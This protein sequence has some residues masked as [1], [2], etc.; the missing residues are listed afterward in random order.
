[1]QNEGKIRTMLES[2]RE[3]QEHDLL[4]QLEQDRSKEKSEWVRG[5]ESFPSGNSHLFCWRLSHFCSPLSL[6]PC[7]II[8]IFQMQGIIDDELSKPL[9][10][11]EDYMQTFEA[12]EAVLRSKREAD[13]RQHV[14][15]VGHLEKK[16]WQR[17]AAAREGLVSETSVWCR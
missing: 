10:V 15:S 3:L 16:L 6:C 17:E 13:R 2:S 14:A 9:E 12:E 8:D 7:L 1:M 5:F 4:R 11:T